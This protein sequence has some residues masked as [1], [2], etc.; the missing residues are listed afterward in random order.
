M[1]TITIVKYDDT[2]KE[3]LNRLLLSFS[4][5]VFNEETANIDQFVD[6]HWCIY[7]ALK[8]GE[9]VGFTSFIYNTY[10][11]MRTPTVGNDYAYIVPHHRGS[12]TMYLF[13]LQAGKVSLQYDLPLEVYYASDDSRRLGK[14]IQGDLMYEAIIYPTSEISRKFKALTTKIEIKND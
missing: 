9:V 12:K 13:S 3:D 14:Q 10:Y 8:D 11:G 2:Y 6:Y 7:L 1:S 4:R 5:E